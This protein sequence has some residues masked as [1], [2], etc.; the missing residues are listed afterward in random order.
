MTSDERNKKLKYGPEV[1]RSWIPDFNTTHQEQRVDTVN[2]SELLSELDKALRSQRRAIR[3]GKAKPVTLKQ[4]RKV[5]STNLPRSLAVLAGFLF[6]ALIGLN[7]AFYATGS[8]IH[9]RESSREQFSLLPISILLT[10]SGG[11]SLTVAAIIKRNGR[12]RI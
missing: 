7:L 11:A 4:V 3:H 6:A 9:E 5:H 10:L 12:R 8:R 1:P 2:T